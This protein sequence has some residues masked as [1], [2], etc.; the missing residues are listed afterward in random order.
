M[1]FKSPEELTIRDAGEE[2][3]SEGLAHYKVIEKHTDGS[4]DRPMCVE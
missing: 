3:H 1:Q 4:E 2:I